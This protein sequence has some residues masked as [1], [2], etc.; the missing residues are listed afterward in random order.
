MDSY[1]KAIFKHNKLQSFTAWKDFDNWENY[2][3]KDLNENAV[4]WYDGKIQEIRFECCEIAN[5]F[6]ESIKNKPKVFWK[7]GHKYKSEL[8]D[9]N[10]N[11]DCWEYYL[12]NPFA[13]N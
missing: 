11:M 2:F 4:F 1:S 8:F 10:I 6:Y 3:G 7:N 9:N 12:K 5:N 13:I